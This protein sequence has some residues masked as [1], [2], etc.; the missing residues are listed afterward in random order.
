MLYGPSQRR[1]KSEDWYMYRQKGSPTRFSAANRMPTR[2][3]AFMMLLPRVMKEFKKNIYFNDASS[4]NSLPS[5]S[6]TRKESRDLG[7][8]FQAYRFQA[9]EGDN[10]PSRGDNSPNP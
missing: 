3:K 8:R 6:F 9:M 7:G 2:Q 1:D 10:S 5:Y 4:L